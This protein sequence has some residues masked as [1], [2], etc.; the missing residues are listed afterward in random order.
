MLRDGAIA[1]CG[2]PQELYARPLDD[3]LAR[4][5]GEANILDGVL[6]GAFVETP[7]GRLP[8]RWHG[9]TPPSAGP[10]SVLVRPEQIELRPAD[11]ER[12]LSGEIARSGYHGHDAVVYIAIHEGHGEQLLTVRTPGDTNLAAGS[13]VRLL[14]RGP[15][16]VWAG[17][18]TNGHPELLEQ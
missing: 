9:A 14:A 6:D 7:L 1:Q 13:Q 10:V 3:E 12:G 18:S 16:L 17:P 2:P 11:G 8:A 15:M 4:F 5:I